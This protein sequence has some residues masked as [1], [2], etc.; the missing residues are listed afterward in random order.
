MTPMPRQAHS[1]AWELLRITSELDDDMKKDV[2]KKGYSIARVNLTF[3]DMQ[4][5]GHP[6]RDNTQAVDAVKPIDET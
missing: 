5:A 3:D 2:E 1:N 6:S 4:M